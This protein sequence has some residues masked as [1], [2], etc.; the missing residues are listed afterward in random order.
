[1]GGKADLVSELNVIEIERP[2]GS[3]T[4]RDDEKFETLTA[5]NPRPLLVRVIGNILRNQCAN[6][7]RRLVHNHPSGDPTPSRADIDMTQAIVAAAKPLGIAV[8]DHIIVGKDGH[9]S[10]KGLKLI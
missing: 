10:L 4:E 7:R 2:R 8:H 6:A 5:P 9:A 1:L 3:V